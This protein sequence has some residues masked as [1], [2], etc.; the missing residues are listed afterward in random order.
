MGS[1]GYFRGFSGIRPPVL[2]KRETGPAP[3]GVWGQGPN[4][5]RISGCLGRAGAEHHAHQRVSWEGRGQASCASAGVWGGQGPSIMRISGCLGRAGAEHHAH[6]RVSGEGSG[7][8]SCASAG[9]WGGQGPSIM[10]ISGCLGSFKSSP[11]QVQR[12]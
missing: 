1:D 7:R 11:I 5:M 8:A 12:N 3:A 10:R 4:I 2:D 6:Q 9:V